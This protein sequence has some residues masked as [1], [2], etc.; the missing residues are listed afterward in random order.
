MLLRSTQ[1]LAHLVD[2]Y[3]RR[4]AVDGTAL[5]EGLGPPLSGAWVL[6]NALV[7][8]ENVASVWTVEL[9]QV[10]HRE[11]SVPSAEVA[12]WNGQLREAG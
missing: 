5:N 12:D 2:H 9:T 8:L 3:I 1:P 6:G 11:C 4:I 7:Q 10:A